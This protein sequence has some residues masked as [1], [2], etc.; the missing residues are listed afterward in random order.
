MIGN[1]VLRDIPDQLA[2][3]LKNYLFVDNNSIRDLMMET[4]SLCQRPKGS[5][6]AIMRLKAQYKKFS[7]SVDS[8]TKAPYCCL[9]LS[10]AFFKDNYYAEAEKWAN[11]AIDRFDQLNQVRNRSIVRWT[12]ALIYKKNGNVDD[13]EGYFEAAKNQMAQEIQDHKRRSQYDKAKECE[14][15]YSRL[16]EDVRL[17]Q[18]AARVRTR[19]IQLGDNEIGLFQYLLNLV[20]GDRATADGLIDYECGLDPDAG[21]AEHIRRAIEHWNRDNR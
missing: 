4:F 3:I 10:Y 14:T 7:S 21:R 5:K 13:A 11:N 16:L 6:I 9:F 15:V 1:Q 18:E 17:L 2:V 8:L 12:C 20:H 19:A